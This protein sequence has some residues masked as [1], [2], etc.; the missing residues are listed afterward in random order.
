MLD[1]SDSGSCDDWCGNNGKRNIFN[2]NNHRTAI[3]NT[4]A[5]T[6]EKFFAKESKRK[7]KKINYNFHFI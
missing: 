7:L 2:T 4:K 1:H 3:D 6:V 5:H